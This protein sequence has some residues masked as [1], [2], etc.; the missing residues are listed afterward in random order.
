MA[1]TRRRWNAMRHQ[2]RTIP[3][4]FAFVTDPVSSGLVAKPGPGANVTGFTNFE[5]TMGGKW[6]ELLK[7]VKRLPR[8]RLSSTL[9]NSVSRI[10]TVDRGKCT[11]IRRG[12]D[13]ARCLRCR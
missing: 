13:R 7:E 2:T 4:V 11:V 12:V 10:S 9:D 6:L 1:T 8:L 5:F 3:I